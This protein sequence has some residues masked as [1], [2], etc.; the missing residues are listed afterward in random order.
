MDS[1]TWIHKRREYSQQLQN[2]YKEYI[3]KSAELEQMKRQTP[4]N[5]LTDG[6]IIK[7]YNNDGQLVAV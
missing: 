7:G 1:L 4:I 6:Q 2:Y 3:H 5:F